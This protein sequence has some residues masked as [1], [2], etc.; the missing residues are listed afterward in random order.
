MNKA[1]QNANLQV[2]KFTACKRKDE[3][4]WE[5]QSLFVVKVMYMF[6]TTYL[7]VFELFLFL[8]YVSIQLQNMKKSAVSG[9]S[10]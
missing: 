2:K 1:L 9:M 8:K 7:K 3:R 4:I 5:K 6:L 10:K